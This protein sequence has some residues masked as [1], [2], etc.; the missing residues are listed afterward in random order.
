MSDEI[1]IEDITRDVH[2][3][4]DIHDVKICYIEERFGIYRDNTREQELEVLLFFIVCKCQTKSRNLLPE[5]D[6]G[7]PI[8]VGESVDPHLPN[9][10]CSH[11]RCP[12]YHDTQS[13]VLKCRCRCRH[14]SLS[15]PGW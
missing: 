12:Q 3:Y 10:K 1:E 5:F 4:K 7:D 14:E 11:K 13:F 8:K 15:N 6:R 9:K 2:M